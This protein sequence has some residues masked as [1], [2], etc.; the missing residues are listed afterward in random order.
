MFARANVHLRMC[1]RALAIRWTR[2]LGPPP[3][4]SNGLLPNGPLMD[5]QYTNFAPRLGISYSPNSK[6][7][8]RTGYGIF[9]TPGH[10]QRILRHG[11]QYRRARDIYQYGRDSRFT[12]IPV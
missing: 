11:A 5:T 2:P 8:I 9:F 3:V 12:A 7:V 10:R 4:C 1:I 6:L